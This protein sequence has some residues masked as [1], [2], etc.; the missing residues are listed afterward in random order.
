MKGRKFIALMT[1]PD[2]RFGNTTA[3]AVRKRSPNIYPSMA[4]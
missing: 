3:A 4:S 1:A 2:G